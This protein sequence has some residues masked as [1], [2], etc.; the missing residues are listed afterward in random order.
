M[1]GERDNEDKAKEISKMEGKSTR[2]AL[3]MPYQFRVFSKSY[4]KV[5]IPSQFE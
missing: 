1:R 4:Q 2:R 3:Q 5:L